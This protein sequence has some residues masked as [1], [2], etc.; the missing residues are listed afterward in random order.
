MIASVDGGEKGRNLTINVQ[1]FR[2]ERR[3]NSFRRK[4]LIEI[5]FLQRLRVYHGS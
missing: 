3:S 2:E 4:D 1:Y 5:F